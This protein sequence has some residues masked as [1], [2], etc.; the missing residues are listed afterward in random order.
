M[1][2]AGGVAQKMLEISSL[3]LHQAHVCIAQ[4]TDRAEE[5]GL[6]HGGNPQ[7]LISPSPSVS[8]QD[9]MCPMAE[10]LKRKKKIKKEEA[11][12]HYSCHGVVKGLIQC[13]VTDQNTY[14]GNKCRFFSEPASAGT[15]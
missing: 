4:N 2:P 7:E 12:I 13:N 14:S 11:A 1:E 5:K 8:P 9:R 6:Q 15:L 3:K 10:T